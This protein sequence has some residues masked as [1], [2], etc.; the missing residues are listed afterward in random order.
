MSTGVDRWS[1]LRDRE[2]LGEPITGRERDECEALEVADPVVRAQAAPFRERSRM[3]ERASLERPTATDRDIVDRVLLSVRV[4]SGQAVPGS[5]D[6]DAEIERAVDPEGPS[7]VRPTAVAISIFLPAAAAVALLMYEPKA[8][9]RTGPI[10]TQ[11]TP[12]LSPTVVELAHAQTSAR[13]PRLFRSGHVLPWRTDLVEGDR[14]QSGSSVGCLVIDPGVDVCL[15]P[16]SEVKLTSLSRTERSIEVQRGQ[17]IARLDAQAPGDGFELHAGVVRA[18]AQG[19]IYSL[20]RSSTDEVRVRVLEGHVTV[21][22]SDRETVMDAQQMATHRNV[23]EGVS[24][25][26]LPPAHAARM[27][28]LLA[29][30][31]SLSDV[32]SKHAADSAVP[33]AQPGTEPEDQAQPAVLARPVGAVEPTDPARPAQQ[34]NSLPASKS[35][36]DPAAQADPRTRLRDAWQ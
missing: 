31:N 9:P 11:L 34:A 23:D 28:E 15:A 22:A 6:A 10:T 12:T 24:V 2:A 21:L 1:E 18:L 7:W 35:S 33:V 19:T 17:A 20:E 16:D 36:L 14:V 5:V 8:A 29:T 3:L 13:G 26:A 32:A 30:R 4:T 27:W 25:V